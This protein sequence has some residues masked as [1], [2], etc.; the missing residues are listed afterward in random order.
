MAQFVRDETGDHLGETRHHV[1]DAFD[2]PKYGGRNAKDSKK[3]G[4][5]TVI[6]SWQKSPDQCNHGRFEERFVSCD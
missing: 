6:V 3:S 1:G 2:D 4:Q 5:M